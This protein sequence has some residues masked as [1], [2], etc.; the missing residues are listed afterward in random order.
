MKSNID[1]FYVGLH[2]TKP[3]PVFIRKSVRL[4]NKTYAVFQWHGSI[5][6]RIFDSETASTF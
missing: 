1:L 5:F 4:H 2:T 6:N 3:L